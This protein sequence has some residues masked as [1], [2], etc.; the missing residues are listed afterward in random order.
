MH[1]RELEHTTEE[2][3]TIVSPERRPTK[4]Q[5]QQDLGRSES[6]DSL[7]HDILA[8]RVEG[9]KTHLKEPM[10]G[11][12]QTPDLTSPVKLDNQAERLAYAKSN[13]KNS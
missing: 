8:A 7:P 2:S 1:G 6:N 12:S 13:N 5:T 9:S 3:L 4:R 10:S 11:V